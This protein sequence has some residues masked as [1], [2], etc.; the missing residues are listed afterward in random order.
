MPEVQEATSLFFVPTAAA[1]L[2]ACGGWLAIERYGRDF[3]PARRESTTDRRYLDLGLLVAAPAAILLLGQVYR[4]G[5]LLPTSGGAWGAIGWQLDN[6]IIYS[7]IA[8]VLWYR[9]QSPATVYLALDGLWRKIVTGTVLALGAVLVFLLA[10]GEMARAQEVFG[11]VLSGAN[12]RNFLAV[13]LEGVAL[14]F[15][16]VRLRWVVGLTAALVIPSVLFAAAHIP[17]QIEAER[18]LWEMGAF[19]AFN[20]ALAAAILYVV[21]RSQDVIWIAIVHFWMDIATRAFD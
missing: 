4:A 8:A 13:F 12:W 21:A 11:G 16:F 5:Y 7:P 17:R 18:A 15:G 19:F 6:L 10:R 9:R 20:V 1:Y 3:W 2:G 14:A